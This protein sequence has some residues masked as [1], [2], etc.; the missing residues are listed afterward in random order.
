MTATTEAAAPGFT[1]HLPPRWIPLERRPDRVEAQ[2]R[3]ILTQR[4][5][6]AGGD[7]R[8]RRELER[9]L[10]AALRGA[11]AREVRLA[12]LLVEM[13]TD[14]LPVL[15][16]FTL[17]THA[18]PPTGVAGLLQP[19][20]TRIGERVAAVELPFAGSAVKVAYRDRVR[21]PLPR[22]RGGAGMSPA[23]VTVAVTQHLV[24][25]PDGR[26]VVVATGLTPTLALA[27]AFEVLFDALAATLRLSTAE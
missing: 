13:T 16:A 14:G 17:T 2:A 3:A 7:A 25:H 22:G 8:R 20:A 9:D 27:G 23:P 11:S 5:G 21:P 1:L 15:A 19:D 24:P 26:R 6:P 4:L 18:M 10:A 12:A